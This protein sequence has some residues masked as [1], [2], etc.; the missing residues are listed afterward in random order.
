MRKTLLFTVCVGL[1]C[2]GLGRLQGRAQ[3]ASSK[4]SDV[5][6]TRR[7]IREVAD[8]IKRAQNEGDVPVSRGWK[9]SKNSW[10]DPDLEGVYTN[11]DEHRIPF[12]RP[13]EFEG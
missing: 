4:S 9:P 3:T 11:T 6:A 12:E 2:I 7:A 8:S 10:G 1:I 13:I 5:E